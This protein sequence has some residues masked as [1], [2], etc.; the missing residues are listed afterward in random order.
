[1]GYSLIWDGTVDITIRQISNLDRPGLAVLLSRISAFDDDDRSVALE[2]VDW[3]LDNPD[4]RDYLFFVAIAGE[5]ELIGYVCYGPTPL[6]EGTFDL[7][8]IAVDPAWAGQGIGSLLLRKVESTLK[9][10]NGR[11][12]VIET[13]SGQ[14]YALTRQFYMKNG[15]TLAETIKDFYRPGEDRVTFIKKIR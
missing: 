8:W 5:G 4:K 6:T 14:Q 1:M 13:S 11:L 7:Y 2:L 9:E 15:Y 3:N 12:I 10:E